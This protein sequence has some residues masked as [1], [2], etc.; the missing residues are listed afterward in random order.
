MVTS[1]FPSTLRYP[2]I[3]TGTSTVT[4]CVTVMCSVSVGALV[5]APQAFPSNTSQVA[6]ALQFP[7]AAER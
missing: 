6:A 2:E 3:V 1:P 4:V 7:S 5:A